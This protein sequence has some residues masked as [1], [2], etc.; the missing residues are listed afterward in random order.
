MKRT[1]LILTIVF[2]ASLTNAQKSL[3]IY[4]GQ[5]HEIYLGCLNC[6][7]YD[8]SSIWNEYGDYGNSYKTNSIWNSYGK[9]GGSY[10]AESPFNAYAK[11]PPVIVD[12]D[13]KFYGYLTINEYHKDRAEF[14]LAMTIYKYYD[15]I[16]DNVSA[17]YKK[18]FE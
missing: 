13:G 14:G 12:K 9:Y 6:N 16:R 10:S 2:Y 7:D 4:G 3:H 5:D 1:I 15:M 17:W 11:Y 18:I 8:K